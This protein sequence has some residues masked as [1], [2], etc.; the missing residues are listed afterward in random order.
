MLCFDFQYRYSDADIESMEKKHTKQLL[1]LHKTSYLRSDF[2]SD[3]C[4]DLDECAECLKNK[5][6]NK[7][8]LKKLLSTREHVLNKQES[9][10]LRKQRIKEGK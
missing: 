5:E 3:C 7:A 2:C 10:A 6:F 1:K 8:V 4:G 9:K